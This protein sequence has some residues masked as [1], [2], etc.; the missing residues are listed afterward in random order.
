MT[1]KSRAC[2]AVDAEDAMK[3]DIFERG[4][5]AGAKHYK[6]KFRQACQRLG[7]SLDYCP[8]S[9]CKKDC[10]AATNERAACWMK[11][12]E[13]QPFPAPHKGTKGGKDVL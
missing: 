6:G 8:F 12:Y 9:D 3:R 5:E 13:L 1:E 2:I 10:H 11:W 4:R 7:F